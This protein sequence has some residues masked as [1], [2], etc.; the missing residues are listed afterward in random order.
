MKL[1]SR[2]EIYTLQEIEETLHLKDSPCLLFHHNKTE[3]VIQNSHITSEDLL[4]IPGFA[5]TLWR[6]IHTTE[7]WIPVFVST[8]SSILEFVDVAIGVRG[9]VWVTPKGFPRYQ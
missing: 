6:Y 4:G 5:Q 3:C 1:P 7:E 2:G 8:E 9:G